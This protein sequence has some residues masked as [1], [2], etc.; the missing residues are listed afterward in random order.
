MSR[1]E[2]WVIIVD[3][4]DAVRQSLKF[5]LELEG[6]RVRAYRYG[7]E[8]LAER[9]WPARGCLV[10][11]YYM[12]SL[13]GVA[14]VGRLRQSAIEWPAILITAKASA[15]LHRRALQAG[16]RVVLEKPLEDSS[17]VDSIREVLAGGA[18]GAPPA[19]P[20]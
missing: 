17:L 13:D 9:H 5:S 7:E 8:L 15:E 10:I 20:L 19:T 2:G 14:L 1:P 3:D 16:C 18:S 12:P 6:F 4:D 11:D